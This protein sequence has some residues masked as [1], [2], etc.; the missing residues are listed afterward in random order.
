MHN[1]FLDDERFPIGD[2]W[3]IVRSYEEAVEFVLKNGLPNFISFDHDLGTEKT[4]Y[5][6]AK[7]LVDHIMDNDLDKFEFYVHSQNP[8]GKRNIEEYLNGFFNQR[9]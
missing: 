3:E 5:D 1:L 9:I 8:I 7:W 4:G 2:N 6:F